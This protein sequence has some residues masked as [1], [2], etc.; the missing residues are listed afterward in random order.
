[1]RDWYAEGFRL[2]EAQYVKLGAEIV[3]SYV[4]QELVSRAHKVEPT[5]NG[6]VLGNWWFLAHHKLWVRQEW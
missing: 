4:E 5:E 6:V 2:I 1:M 3:V